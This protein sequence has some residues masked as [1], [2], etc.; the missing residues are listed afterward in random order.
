MVKPRSVSGSKSNVVSHSIIIL[1]L[2]LIGLFLAY[3][4]LYKVE[5]FQSTT[6]PPPPLQRKRVSVKYYYLPTCGY[7]KQFDPEWDKFVTMAG[8]MAN[9]EKIEGSTVPP[10]VTGFPH[11]DFIVN[12]GTPEQYLGDRTAFALM[13]KLRSYFVRSAPVV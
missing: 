13:D 12:D 7:C 6:T 9:I 5:G 1:L 4:F 3:I 8:D 11:I 10:H 2:V